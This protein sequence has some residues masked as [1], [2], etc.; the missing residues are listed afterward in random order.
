M[1]NQMQLIDDQLCHR[2]SAASNLCIAL[3]RTF[4]TEMIRRNRDHKPQYTLYDLESV[5]LMHVNTEAF[6]GNQQLLSL[7]K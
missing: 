2:K 5:N 1:Y 6:H 4:T 3:L 7:I